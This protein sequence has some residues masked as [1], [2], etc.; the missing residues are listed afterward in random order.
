MALRFLID[1]CLHTSLA[2]L[3]HEAQYEAVHVA[4]QGLGGTKD[5]PLAEFLLEGE[6]T[7][8]TNNGPDFLRILRRKVSDEGLEIHPGLILFLRNMRPALQSVLFQATL[9][10]LA[11]REDLLNTVL[12]VDLDSATRALLDRGRRLQAASRWG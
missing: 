1:E 2:G 4:H 11:A 12:E 10:Y 9:D 8:V 5:E 6:W 7:L 3:A